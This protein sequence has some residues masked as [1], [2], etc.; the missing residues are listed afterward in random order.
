MARRHTRKLLRLVVLSLLVGL[1]LSLFDISPLNALASI[2]RTAADIF[3]AIVDALA[4]ALPYVIAG[5][6]I[7][8]P[9]WAVWRLVNVMRGKD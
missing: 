7:V 1:V 2:S 8:V 4:W 6:I 9:I 5:A 3:R